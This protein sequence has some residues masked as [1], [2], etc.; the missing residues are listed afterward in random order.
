MQQQDK[1]VRAWNVRY[2]LET[3]KNYP[4]GTCLELRFECHVSFIFSHC[5]STALLHYSILWTTVLPVIKATSSGI[6]QVW[7]ELDSS[8]V[9][10]SAPTWP[11]PNCGNMKE[12]SW[13][14]LSITTID[15]QLSEVFPVVER[16]IISQGN[17]RVCFT[18]VVWLFGTLLN[19]R[20][21]QQNKASGEWIPSLFEEFVVFTV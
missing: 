4:S 18:F 12:S 20:A 15:L 7:L 9:R 17:V 6:T 13:L 10:N 2:Q 19:Q 1:G 11:N 14:R 21:V 5:C 3:A 8:H 16:L